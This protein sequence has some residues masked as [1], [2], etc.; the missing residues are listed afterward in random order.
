MA[1][2]DDCEKYSVCVSGNWL[3]LECG[4]NETFDSTLGY[5]WWLTKCNNEGCPT[6]PPGVTPKPKPETAP[7]WTD[8]NSTCNRLDRRAD[9][10]SCYHY[11]DCNGDKWERKSCTNLKVY[12]IN[13]NKCIQ[14]WGGF[15]CD[16]RC[17]AI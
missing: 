7:C 13:D 3:E 8:V 1:N 14:P 4:Q 17:L 16:T 12:D 15:D 6:E 11:Y 5:C 9:Q 10:S 2:P